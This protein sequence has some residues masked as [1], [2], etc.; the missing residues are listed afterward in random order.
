MYARVVVRE[1]LVAPGKA[2]VLEEDDDSSLEVLGGAG[3][4]A[5]GRPR[6]P[7]PLPAGRSDTE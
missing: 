3:W 5:P 2:A 4:P 6:G 7:G 1:G